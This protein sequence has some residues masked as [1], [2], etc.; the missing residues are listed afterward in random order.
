MGWS[1][2]VVIPPDG[3]MGDKVASLKLMAREDTASTTPPTAPRVQR[4]HQ[5]VRGMIGHRRQREKPD[6]AAVG[7]TFADSQRFHSDTWRWADEFGS[8]PL[9]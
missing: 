6:C 7:G 5:L 3:D 1:T 8:A 4:P 9:R 2:S